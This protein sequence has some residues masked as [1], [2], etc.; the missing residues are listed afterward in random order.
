MSNHFIDDLKLLSE[1][2][3]NLSGYFYVGEPLRG[4]CVF[5]CTI[6]SYGIL[7][8]GFILLMTDQSE[9][10]QLTGPIAI[11][12]GAIGSV[13]ITTWSIFDVVKIA[14]IKNL[15]YQENKINMELKPEL[16]ILSQK[17]N[18]SAI[19]GLRLSINF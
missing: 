13:I 8:S 7:F 4:A 16:F 11:L 9:P 15:A 1:L 14:K 5:G 17:N 3:T 12:S 10:V 19:Y 6:V 2:S 18:N